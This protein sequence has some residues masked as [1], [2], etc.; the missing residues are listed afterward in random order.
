MTQI[1]L[2]QRVGVK[3]LTISRLERG[4]PTVKLSTRAKIAELLGLTF[5]WESQQIIPSANI[6]EDAINAVMR[7]GSKPRTGASVQIAKV[8]SLVD[9]KSREMFEVVEEDSGAAVVLAAAVVA[10]AE[11]DEQHRDVLI[12][13]AAHNAKRLGASKGKR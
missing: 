6:T 3:H 10:L 2:S 1:D 8:L 11:A 5:N 4:D 13:R 9:K 7:Q 12:E